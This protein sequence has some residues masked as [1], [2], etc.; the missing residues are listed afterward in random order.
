MTSVVVCPIR[1]TDSLPAMRHFLELLGLR[2]RIESE[3]GGWVDMVAGAGMV[4]LHSAAESASGA[5][6][7][8]TRLG[9]EADDV[10]LLAARL[11]RC[12]VPDA[13]VYDEAY[14][15]VLTCTDPLGD[16]IAVNGRSTDLHGYRTHQA[17]PDDRWRVMPVRFTSPLGPYGDFLEVLGLLRRGKPNDYYVIHAGPDRAGQVGLHYV[18]SG[19]LPL[20][21]GPAAVHLTFE[22]DEALE[23]VADR[24]A[25]HGHSDA[26]ITTE[27]FGSMLTVTD[28]DGRECQVHTPPAADG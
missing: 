11:R 3:R 21:P 19:D 24:L 8:E 2:P 10:R 26:T 5:T 15:E 27:S 12:G 6:A 7:G 4:A 28:P 14:G 16:A 13:T 25:S 9:F 17:E 1:F 20:V 23:S 22:T 18:Y